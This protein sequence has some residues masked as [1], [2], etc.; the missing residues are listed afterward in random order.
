MDF[1]LASCLEHYRNGG[2]RKASLACVPR[3]LGRAAERVYPTRYLRAY[4]EKF[5]PGWEPRWLAVP[6]AWQRG[7]ALLAVA[8]VYCP[9]GLRR[10]LKANR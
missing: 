8:R 1:L 7:P 2:V 3:L 10:A 6:V 9:G 4:K 5:A